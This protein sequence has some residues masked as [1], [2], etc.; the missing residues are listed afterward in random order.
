LSVC[1]LPVTLHGMHDVQRS[2]VCALP[3]TLHGMHDVQ[4]SSVCA[5]PVSL[6]GMH[7]VSEAIHL[8][9]YSRQCFFRI[10]TFDHCTTVHGRSIYQYVD[11][12]V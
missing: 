2:S 3:V 1:A 9:S 8:P 10:P 7:D 11:V 4:R 6:H 12:L 5:L